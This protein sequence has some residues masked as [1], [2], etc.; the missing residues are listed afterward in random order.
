MKHLSTA[1]E[2][3]TRISGYVVGGC[4]SLDSGPRPPQHL[5]AAKGRKRGLAIGSSFTRPCRPPRICTGFP[6]YDR[7]MAW[8]PDGM[9]SV[10]AR[11]QSDVAGH[12]AQ[13]VRPSQIPRLR[14]GMTRAGQILAAMFLQ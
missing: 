11:G 12:W 1:Y 14:Y 2:G 8:H 7:V 3:L 5:P 9:E 4:C 6:R 10:R 13:L